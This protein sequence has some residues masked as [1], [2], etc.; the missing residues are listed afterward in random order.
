MRESLLPVAVPQPGRLARPFRPLTGADAWALR[1]RWSRWCQRVVWKASVPGWV[2]TAVGLGL[3]SV[4]SLPVGVLTAVGGAMAAALAAQ[5]AG[6]RAFASSDAFFERE[7][8]LEGSDSTTVL[9]VISTA[10]PL[11][12]RDASHPAIDAMARD[13]NI[14]GVRTTVWLVQ[15]AAARE[16]IEGWRPV[17]SPAA[18]AFA[19]AVLSMRAGKRDQAGATVEAA[20]E[21]DLSPGE[22]AA[23]SRLRA[24]LA[25]GV[26]MADDD[27][28]ER[29]RMLRALADLSQAGQ[30]AWQA[31]DRGK[32]LWRM[33]DLDAA[34]TEGLGTDIPPLEL[35]RVAAALGRA[36][37]T[38]E[39]LD[40]RT[41]FANI[42]G[43]FHRV[44]LWL[45]V[46]GGEADVEDALVHW[47]QQEGPAA[48]WP[49]VVE[50]VR[51]LLRA[52]RDGAAALAG[53]HAEQAA[54]L[55]EEARE[56]ALRAVDAAVHDRVLADLV[57][58]A[59]SGVLDEA[60]EKRART[61][62][63]RVRARGPFVPPPGQ[64][65]AGAPSGGPAG[66]R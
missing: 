58:L 19:D 57:L 9:A 24:M 31:Q 16:V 10:L 44:F 63:D 40:D 66:A 54:W 14:T 7:A 42:L 25:V 27:D 39:I 41:A 15:E 6:R 50:V 59:D 55:V 8:A 2:V 22:N 46:P 12:V 28:V 51:D 56:L 65:A 60:R 20:L 26:P 13:I 4:G 1:R 52:R 38:A 17:L 43:G 36:A 18:L 47:A 29:D 3:I 21:G 49:G 45:W 62:A 48:A 23:L 34:W 33:G 37:K 53:T 61:T 5:R 35:P 30:E 32:V 11:G 64:G